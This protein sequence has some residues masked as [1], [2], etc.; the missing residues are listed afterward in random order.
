LDLKLESTKLLY[1]V[2]L[3][4]EGPIGKARSLFLFLSRAAALCCGACMYAIIDVA[5]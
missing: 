3:L 2:S 1:I 4:L 5:T